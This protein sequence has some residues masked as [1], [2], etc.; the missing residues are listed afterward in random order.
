MSDA[1]LMKTAT[2]GETCV[3]RAACVRGFWRARKLPVRTGESRACPLNARAIRACALRAHARPARGTHRRQQRG[4]GLIEVMLAAAVL[5]VGIVGAT[6]MLGESSVQIEANR[7]DM[8]ALNAARRK[9]S[10]MEALCGSSSA[11]SFDSIFN[12]YKSGQP[13]NTE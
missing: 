11:G 7:E 1:R 6:S 9:L 2:V 10:D 3:P 4:I 8:L 5:A 13:A 12:L